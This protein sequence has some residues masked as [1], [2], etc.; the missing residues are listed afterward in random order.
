MDRVR[1]E[2][3]STLDE[4]E[5]F[6]TARGYSGLTFT[7]GYQPEVVITPPHVTVTVAPSSPK[8]LELGRVQGQN[9]LYQRSIVV[10]A[11]MENEGR[12]TSIMDAVMDFMEWTCVDI[13]DHTTTNH[14]TLICND[15]DGIL[16]QVF[17]PVMTM[18]QNTRWRAAITGPFEAFYPNA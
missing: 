14:G 11:Y 2:Q 12:A 15:I 8:T 17:P 9:S 4:L 18:P 13:V 3:R 5:D 10:N 6:L 16:G 1:I 7:D